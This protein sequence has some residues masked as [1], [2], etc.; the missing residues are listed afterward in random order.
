VLAN[1]IEGPQLAPSIADRE[2][3]LA[4]NGTGQIATRLAQLFTVAEK[5]PRAEENR[6]ALYS[7]VLRVTVAFGR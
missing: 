6:L 2:N 3:A 1:V 7:K 4:L 5:L